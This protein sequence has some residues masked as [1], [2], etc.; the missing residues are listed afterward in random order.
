M[1]VGPLGRS[2]EVEPERAHPARHRAP[3]S[4]RARRGTGER[5]ADE[6]HEADRGDDADRVAQEPHDRV[7][8]RR[9]GGLRQDARRRRRHVGVAAAARARSPSASMATTAETP[10]P[11][12]RS[13]TV[14]RHRDG[15]SQHDD[16]DD[17]QRDGERLQGAQGG[18]YRPELRG[19]EQ[20]HVPAR[21]GVRHLL[22]D[23]HPARHERLLH[24]GDDGGDVDRHR[25][26]LDRD[27][28]VA[29]L[30]RE[31]R[32]DDALVRAAV[33]LRPQLLEL[34]RRQGAFGVRPWSSRA[35]R[36]RPGAR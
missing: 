14:R 36:T 9:R 3:Q 18:L 6:Q 34:R 10:R 24:L 1:A 26:C 35:A 27:G 23:R 17:R 22:H 5:R 21:G 12:Q 8:E 4:H 33:H 16:G 13:P 28:R 25:T 20:H 2:A 15:D 7:E 30:T 32:R 11:Q 19:L 31:Q 29:T